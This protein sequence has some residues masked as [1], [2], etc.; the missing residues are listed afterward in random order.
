MRWKTSTSRSEREAGRD[1]NPYVGETEEQTVTFDRYSVWNI[2][3]K[4]VDKVATSL[5]IAASANSMGDSM[6]VPFNP[7]S[8]KAFKTAPG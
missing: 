6:R 2:A 1:S 3:P 4:G 8:A 7:R 5:V